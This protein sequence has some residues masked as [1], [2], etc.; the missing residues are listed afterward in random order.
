MT[1]RSIGVSV[2]L[3]ILTLAVWFLPQTSR[4]QASY[5]VIKLGTLGGLNSVANSINN[6]GKVVGWA[7]T[8]SGAQHAAFWLNGGVADLNYSLPSNSPWVLNVATSINSFGDIVGIGTYN[9]TTAAFYDNGGGVTL[10]GIGESANA[11]NDSNQVV[12]SILNSNPN[13]N[14]AFI[15]SPTTGGSTLPNLTSGGFSNAYDINNSGVI[16]GVSQY[17]TSNVFDY[18]PTLWSLSGGIYVPTDLGN[19]GS[20]PGMAPDGSAS[21]I[22]ST[23]EV[24]GWST[25]PNSAQFTAYLDPT[26]TP[27]N[28]INL[29]NLNG[30]G[31][32]DFAQSIN[33]SGDVVGAAHAGPFGSPVSNAWIW[34]PPP[35]ML[36]LVDLD[37]PF[38]SSGTLNWATGINNKNEIVGGAPSTASSRPFSSAQPFPEPSG[39]LT[40]LIFAGL[41]AFLVLNA[42]RRNRKAFTRAIK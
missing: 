35:S 28:F 20:L 34:Y 26:G 42:T 40:S 31:N 10:I 21:A 1:Q 7:D 24:V 16:A 23:G 37:I 2:I 11:I 27:G 32:K 5:Q 22:S 17:N 18:N 9:G 30:D 12:G 6:T 8:S 36:P 25:V 13:L 41:L 14:Q 38:P 15:W 39:L 3:T 19:M 29:G 4:A 33:S